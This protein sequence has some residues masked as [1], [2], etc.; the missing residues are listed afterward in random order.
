MDLLVVV[1]D[2]VIPPRLAARTR[3]T[4][5]V[6]VDDELLTLVADLRGHIPRR[7]GVLGPGADAAPIAQQLHERG[8]PIV[9]HTDDD[10][11]VPGAPR[12]AVSDGGEPMDVADDLIGL[13]GNTPMIRLDHTARDV[14]CHLLAKLELFNPASRRRTGP[15]WR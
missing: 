14:D 9:L 12:V 10:V 7:V 4:M 6:A 15:P 2:A 8:L 5:R 11:A 3:R 13:I 1:G